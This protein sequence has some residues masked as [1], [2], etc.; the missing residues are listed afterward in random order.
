MRSA[1]RTVRH[2][3][4]P[5]TKLTGSL[6]EKSWP[7]V[8]CPTCGDGVLRLE[9]AFTIFDSATQNLPSY[10]PPPPFELKGRFT[11]LLECDDAACAEGVAV[12]GDWY[13]DHTQEPPSSGGDRWIDYYTV[14]F[15]HP[16][17]T[18]MHLPMGTPARVVAAVESAS[19]V[20]WASP[21]SAAN[22]LRFDR[23]AA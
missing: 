13:V 12:A 17:L 2:V 3:A 10:P 21:A 16:P 20:L 6:T 7:G 4:Q 19:S 8:A 5:L 18:I 1:S 23:G 11:G 22:R 9:G 15:V 14:R